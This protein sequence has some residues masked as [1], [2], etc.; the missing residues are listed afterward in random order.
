MAKDSDAARPSFRHE[1]IGHAITA[2]VLALSLVLLG[3][4]L[5]DF[6]DKRDKLEREA[7]LIAD[8]IGDNASAAVAFDDARNAREILSSATRAGYI[9]AAVIRSSN[10][11]VLAR[12]GDRNWQPAVVPATTEKGFLGNTEIVRPIRLDGE[13]IGEVCLRVSYGAARDAF[14]EDVLLSFLALCLAGVIVFGLLYRT[15]RPLTQRLSMIS[16]TMA[17]ITAND[18]YQLRLPEADT[19]E[20]QEI[21]VLSSSLNTML[22]EIQRHRPASSPSWNSADLPRPSCANCPRPWKTRQPAFL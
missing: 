14:L 8:I 15:L 3:S 20:V 9:K 19:R 22:G 1:I 16:S 6:V 5:R 11:E 2:I 4:G 18:D 7:T 13:R 17:S 12:L 21:A 10:G